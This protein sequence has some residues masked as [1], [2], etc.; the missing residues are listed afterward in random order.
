MAAKRRRNAFSTYSRRLCRVPYTACFPHVFEPSFECNSH[1]GLCIRHTVYTANVSLLLLSS[2]NYGYTI[3]V[4]FARC[5]CIIVIIIP[6]RKAHAPCAIRSMHKNAAEIAHEEKK[7]LRCHWLGFGPCISFT[8][9]LWFWLWLSPTV[10][11]QYIC[12][13]HFHKFRCYVRMHSNNKPHC[14]ICAA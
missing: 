8:L 14:H 5:I 11:L 10:P 7:N 12:Y 1:L 13:V 3:S 2:I 9:W 6:M 4:F